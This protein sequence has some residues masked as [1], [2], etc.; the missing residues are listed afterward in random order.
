M[1]DILNK[2]SNPSI[3]TMIFLFSSILQPETQGLIYET[4][5]KCYNC[6]QVWINKL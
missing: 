5:G 4:S 2:T 1:T 6:F 3:A